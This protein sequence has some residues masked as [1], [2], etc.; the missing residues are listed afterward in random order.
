MSDVIFEEK[1][2]KLYTHEAEQSQI[3]DA[4]KMKNNY[5]LHN[6]LYGS[7]LKDVHKWHRIYGRNES[8]KKS[9]QTHTRA[10]GVFVIRGAVLRQN[11]KLNWFILLLFL[12]T[13]WRIIIFLFYFSRRFVFLIEIET[14]RMIHEIQLISDHFTAG[15][16]CQSQHITVQ[17]MCIAIAISKINHKIC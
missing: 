13:E 8:N 10:Q 16:L 12:H 14:F 5:R 9:T 2:K 15:S 17:I 3:A 7:V 1:K 4:K 6:G 11:T